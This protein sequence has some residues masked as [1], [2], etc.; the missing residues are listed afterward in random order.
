MTQP[1]QTKNDVRPLTWRD[2][3]SIVRIADDMCNNLEYEKVLKMGEEG[4]YTEVLRRFNEGRV[5]RH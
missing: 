3:Q 5:M 1:E 2:V 4:Y